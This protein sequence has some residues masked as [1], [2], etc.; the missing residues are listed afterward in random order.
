M[1]FRA[2]EASGEAQSHVGNEWSDPVDKDRGPGNGGQ[3][4][5]EGVQ[6][7]K[8]GE[9]GSPEEPPGVNVQDP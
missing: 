9:A 4:G 5:R 6:V 7:R 3:V 2:A 8:A 1:E